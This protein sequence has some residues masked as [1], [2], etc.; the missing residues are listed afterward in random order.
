[1]NGE[2]GGSFD[3]TS[4]S[5]IPGSDEAAQYMQSV[6]GSE[7]GGAYL[8]NMQSLMVTDQSLVNYDDSSQASDAMEEWVPLFATRQLQ[9]KSV[10]PPVQSGRLEG[11]YYISPNWAPSVSYKHTLRDIRE[12]F[13]P[14]EYYKYRLQ[15]AGR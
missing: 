3:A 8:G 12:Q 11:Q 13:T 4:P 7:F 1:M 5:R 10:N 6:A 14:A 9:R 2:N 15:T